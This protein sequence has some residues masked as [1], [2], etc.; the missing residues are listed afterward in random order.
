MEPKQSLLVYG[1]KWEFRDDTLANPI[2][3]SNGGKRASQ[4]R[5]LHRE[6]CTEG[7]SGDGKGVPL[8][9][10]W[11]LVRV[12]MWRSCTHQEWVGGIIPELGGKE[13]W[14]PHSRVEKSCNTWSCPQKEK[15]TPRPVSFVVHKCDDWV[16]CSCVR[17]ASSNL[18]MMSAH[19]PSDLEKKNPCTKG[20][21]GSI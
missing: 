8:L 3:E 5:E 13:L 11:V 1:H 21:S 6:T 7:E 15:S 18:V 10:S 12:W 19:H 16:F 9:F 14:C 20:C 4:G 2:E 17:C